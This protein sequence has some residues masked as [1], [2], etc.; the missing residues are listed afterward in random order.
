MIK[1]VENINKEFGPDTIDKTTVS[2]LLQSTP[3][4]ELHRR[5]KSNYLLKTRHTR[6]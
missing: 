4:D 5:L 1:V 6:K 2:N 3:Q